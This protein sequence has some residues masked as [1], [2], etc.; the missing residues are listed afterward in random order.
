MEGL[1]ALSL[2]SRERER[3]NTEGAHAPLITSACLS[4]LP[5]A[6]HECCVRKP[7]ALEP[8]LG[9]V[10]E[11]ERTDRDARHARIQ[12][13]CARVGDSRGRGDRG[14]G[15]ASLDGEISEPHGGGVC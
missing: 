11:S 9:G 5:S 6:A 15:K 13:A 10:S 7:R 1:R 2:A 4:V 8:P 14:A 12:D 3:R